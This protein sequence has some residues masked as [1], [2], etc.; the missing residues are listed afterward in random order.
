MPLFL[1]VLGIILLW[2]MT[3]F[4]LVWAINTL[5]HTAFAISSFPEW[6]AGLLLASPV[7]WRSE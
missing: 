5:F 4:V 1:L 6:L 7:V 2:I 3:P